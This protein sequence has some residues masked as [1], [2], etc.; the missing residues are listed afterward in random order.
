MP[1]FENKTI[2]YSVDGGTNW[3]TITF[4]NGIHSNTGWPWRW[5]S[6]IH[7]EK[8]HVKADKTY[9]INLTFVLSTSKVIIQLFNNYQLDFRNSKFGELI[10]F[11]TRISYTNRIW[12]QITNYYKFNWCD[13]CQ[14][15]CNSWFTGCWN[16]FKHHYCDSKKLIISQDHFHFYMS[17]DFYRILL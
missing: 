17:Q 9:G 2:K 1:E 8:G 12:R 7:E 4:V 15:W 14:L 13:K 5:Y 11:L 3:E 6:W 16:I 10:G